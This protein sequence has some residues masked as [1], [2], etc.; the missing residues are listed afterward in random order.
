MTTT[1]KIIWIFLLVAAC[2]LALALF[3][4]AAAGM[5]VRTNSRMPT[6]NASCALGEVGL[7]RDTL[8]FDRAASTRPDACARRLS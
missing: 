7:L 2:A 3:P 4:R 5:S 8:H 6:A 1:T